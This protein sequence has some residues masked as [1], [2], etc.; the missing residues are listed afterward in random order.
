MPPSASPLSLDS[1]D[2]FSS[3]ESQDAYCNGGDDT[4]VLIPGTPTCPS[5]EEGTPHI[6][7]KR[8]FGS[9]NGSISNGTLSQENVTS[10]PRNRLKRFGSVTE[11]NLAA[12]IMTNPGSSEDNLINSTTSLDSCTP[13]KSLHARRD[14]ILNFTLG[15]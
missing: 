3:M 7:S 1:C 6:V 5:S 9:C 4:E 11:T 8:L 13:Q 12:T 14:V 10:L 15:K 2:G